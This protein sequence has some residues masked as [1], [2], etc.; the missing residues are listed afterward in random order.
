MQLY[1]FLI[2][3][4]YLY[5]FTFKSY[6]ILIFSIMMFLHLHKKYINNY[7]IQGK[8]KVLVNICN[9]PINFY[10]KISSY[11]YDN[12]FCIAIFIC[13]EKIN[14]YYIFLLEEVT[15]M[16]SDLIFDQFNELLKKS[17]KNSS[18]DVNNE[19]F[20]KMFTNMMKVFPE[21]K[22]KNR[23]NK[24]LL[25]SIKLENDLKFREIDDY[26]VSDFSELNKYSIDDLNDLNNNLLSIKES[27]EET[28]DNVNH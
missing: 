19:L 10:N 3:F 24:D 4:I 22:P 17:N 28:L 13:Y 6:F 2:S 7:Q 18:N 20:N 16:F 1:Q 27:L 14:Q 12:N 8:N 5:Y 23:S 26:N 21:N 11:D 15:C 9:I 25:K